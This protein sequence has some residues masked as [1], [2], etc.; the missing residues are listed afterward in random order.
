MIFRVHK[1]RRLY[2]R[3]ALDTQR[4]FSIPL[5]HKQLIETAQK[6]LKKARTS[7]VEQCRELS[8]SFL[9][10]YDVIELAT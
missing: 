3:K 10:T 1:T 5:S 6:S 9:K 8:L 2:L 4:E 7:V